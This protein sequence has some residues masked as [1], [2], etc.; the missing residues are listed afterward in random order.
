MAPCKKV[1]GGATFKGKTKATA[2]GA[3]SK[4][5]Y[6]PFIKGIAPATL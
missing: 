3:T 2:G 1:I 4:R 5:Y 6:Q